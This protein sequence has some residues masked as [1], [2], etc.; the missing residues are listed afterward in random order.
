MESEASAFRLQ[1]W[2]LDMMVG[3]MVYLERVK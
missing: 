3:S 2:I 1:G